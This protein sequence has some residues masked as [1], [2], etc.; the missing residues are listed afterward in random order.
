MDK[1]EIEPWTE[2]AIT[3]PTVQWARQQGIYHYY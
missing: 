3:G 1:T 2:D